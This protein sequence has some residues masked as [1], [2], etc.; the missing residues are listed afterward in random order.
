LNPLRE[1]GGPRGSGMLFLWIRILNRL[2]HCRQKK[3]VWM[4]GQ[5]HAVCRLEIHAL[6]INHKRR[7]GFF[8]AVKSDK[9]N[10]CSGQMEKN[11]I[12]D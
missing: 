9:L 3:S 7:H 6:L 5:G 2:K 4:S 10:S 1:A 12:C 11:P 8:Q